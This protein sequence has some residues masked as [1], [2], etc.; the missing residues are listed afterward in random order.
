MSMK[1]RC[2]MKCGENRE[3][4]KFDTFREDNVVIFDNAGLPSIM[5]KFTRNPDKPVHPMFVI[6]GKTY[7]E[8]YIS[9]YPNVIIN[10]K[11]Y[12]L[13]LQEPA[14]NITLDHAEKACFSKGEGWHLMTAME[15]GYIANL[16]HDTGI[17]PH[18]NTQGGVYH[19][20]QSEKGVT[21]N[22]RGNTLTGSGPGTWT[23]DHTVFGI[24][25][26]RGNIWEWIRGLR[27]IDGVLQVAENNDAAMNIDLSEHSQ[28]WKLV[29]DGEKP[30]KLDCTD[31]GEVVFTTSRRVDANDGCR[32]K[33][34]NFDCEE[35]QEM[36][37]LGLFS[38]EPEAYFYANT[39]GE[40][41]P[42]FGGCYSGG[43]FTGVFSVHLN[44][45]RS[46]SHGCVG[47]RSAY[48]R[49]LETE[50]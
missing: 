25:D 34:I 24:H 16:C 49:K 27:L 22:K 32:W 7:D 48:Y 29:T 33:E 5:V 42:R 15:R 12:S 37:D 20:D 40:V 43:S 10:G 17:F 47:F 8:V 4:P 18:G 26:L 23:H 28:N 1:V 13:P 6:G 44:L 39:Y 14:V 11:A 46:D 41:F 9:K 19:A 45:S 36:K 38:G 3:K 30:I 21:Y 35:T 2:N 50:D 31:R